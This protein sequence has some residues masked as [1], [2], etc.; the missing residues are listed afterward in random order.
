MRARRVS[1]LTPH[2]GGAVKRRTILAPIAALVLVAAPVAAQQ[3]PQQLPQQP[4]QQ[5]VLDSA[6]VAAQAAALVL[7]AT[8]EGQTAAANVGSS[9]WFVGGFASGIVLGLVGTA[10]TWALAA[11]SEVEVAPD[12][13]LLISSRSATYQQ[14]YQKAY[15]DKVKSKRKVS[16]L[17]GGLLG[18]ATI[19]TIYLSAMASDGY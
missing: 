7:Q 8:A 12:K 4:S 15:G 10:I 13:R 19:L 16:A 17:T 6:A 11:N 9:G 14:L 5:G 18:T 2:H 3:P 1:G